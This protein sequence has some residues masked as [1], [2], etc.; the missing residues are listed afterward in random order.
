[1]FSDVPVLIDW[2]GGKGANFGEPVTTHYLRGSVLV[3]I[4]G[5]LLSSAVFQ[6]HTRLLPKLW[7][8]G[9]HRLSVADERFF[10]PHLLVPQSATYKQ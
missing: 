10:F 7:A 9:F 3:D 5:K 6:L 1:M 8:R 2:R 4:S